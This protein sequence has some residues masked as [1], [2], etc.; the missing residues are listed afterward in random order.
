MRNGVKHIH[1]ILGLRAGMRALR[2][3]CVDETNERGMNVARALSSQ[4]EKHIIWICVMLEVFSVFRI[5][6]NLS[7]LWM[8]SLVSRTWGC[9]NKIA[10]EGSSGRVVEGNKNVRTFAGG[11]MQ[12][13]SVIRDLALMYGRGSCLKGI[14]M[15]NISGR[16]WKL[17]RDEES[18]IVRRRVAND[19]MQRAIDAVT[20]GIVEEVACIDLNAGCIM[21]TQW[22]NEFSAIAVSRREQGHQ[23]VKC[24]GVAEK[25]LIAAVEVAAR[26]SR[27]I[28]G[29]TH[30]W[31]ARSNELGIDSRVMRQWRAN[32]KLILIKLFCKRVLKFEAL[33]RSAEKPERWRIFQVST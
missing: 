17:V 32:W 21:Q 14:P 7:S 24:K 28:E 25:G 4:W 2:E 23:R 5:A 3:K 12:R 9:K 22:I 18:N 20:K 10:K 6:R 19:G 11:K 8:N 15:M 27:S 31:E 33:N 26:D 1:L 29:E 16:F 30:M 13:R